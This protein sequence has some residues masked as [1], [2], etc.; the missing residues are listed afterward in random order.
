MTTG[1]LTRTTTG[2]RIRTRM[3]RQSSRPMCIMIT[4]MN[5]IMHRLMR[6]LM[7][8]VT[9]TIMIMHIRSPTVTNRRP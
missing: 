4:D 9:R 1:T 2:I 7:I 5:I 3:S 6:T 8:T